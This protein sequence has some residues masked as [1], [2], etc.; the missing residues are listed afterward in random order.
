MN[1]ENNVDV[2]LR[3]QAAKLGKDTKIVI[4]NIKTVCNRLRNS[5]IISGRVFL[6]YETTLDCATL[7]TQ[8]PK[9]AFMVYLEAAAYL[10]RCP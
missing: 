5:S 8:Y 7:K 10:Y 4:Y 3:N 9:E 6:D 2:Q 1:I